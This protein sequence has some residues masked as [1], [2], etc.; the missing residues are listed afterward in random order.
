VAEDTDDVV[1]NVIPGVGGEDPYYRAKYNGLAGIMPGSTA[2]G[3][4]GGPG[5]P[6][7]D[8][9]DQTLYITAAN[10]VP[11]EPL[12]GALF[13]VGD[14]CNGVGGFSV[15]GSP[16][17]PQDVPALLQVLNICTPCLDCLTY[18]Q[19]E[20]YLDRIRA[21]YDYICELCLN[22]NT[23]IP[24]IPPS[25]LSSE[26]FSGVLPQL[27]SSLRYWDYLVHQ[28]TVKLAAQAYGQSLVAAGFYRNISDQTVG[29]G[30]P[31]GVKL[32]FLFTFEIVY[33]GTGSSAPWN[34][35]TAAISDI[36]I[37]DRV[38][39]CSAALGPL[40]TVIGTNTVT[41][42]TVSVHD[43][44]PGQEI[45]ADVALVLLGAV[46]ANIP[47]ENY[48]VTVKLTAAPT[49]LGPSVERTT[50]VYFRPPDPAPS[51]GP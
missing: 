1:M 21:F 27:L 37:L 30:A 5:Q 22:E 11:G 33:E 19:I 10:G 48:R 16:N 45:Y 17:W 41:V 15:P 46:L 49:H 8:F 12:S 29:V 13:V 28:S 40:G 38:G 4:A 39:R 36:R 42:E 7:W 43:L 9:T 50:V 23:T 32:T 34:G 44:A 31:T 51:G 25:G 2:N 3:P 18:Y 26:Q 47:G 14:V 24:P 35:I 6:A 20:E